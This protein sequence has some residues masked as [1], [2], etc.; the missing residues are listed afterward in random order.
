[1]P[2]NEIKNVQIRQAMF[3][4]TIV[5]E[6]IKQPFVISPSP[7]IIAVSKFA[8]NPH[9]FNKL[10]KE[11]NKAFEVST[12]SSTKVKQITPP[13]KRSDSTDAIMLCEKLKLFVVIVFCVD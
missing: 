6:S 4:F 9:L 5:D 12:S 7:Q 13:I 2:P 1:M 3:E 8:F 11:T 10:A